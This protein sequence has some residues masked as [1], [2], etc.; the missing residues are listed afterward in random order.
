MPE[1]VRVTV[2]YADA[3]G[4]S[5][6]LDESLSLDRVPASVPGNFLFV[7]PGQQATGLGLLM[8]PPGQRSDWHPAPWE[9][10][11]LIVRGAVEIEVCDGERRRFQPGDILRLTDVTGRG[12]VTNVVGPDS[13]LVARVRTSVDAAL[14]N[15]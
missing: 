3:K 10:F 8:I 1:D 6:F 11:S 15:R 12:H 5:H 14:L 4:E 13:A 9:H 7:S 2:V